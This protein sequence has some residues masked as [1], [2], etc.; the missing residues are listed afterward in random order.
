MCVVSS[1][2]MLSVAK[3]VLSVFFRSLHFITSL[4]HTHTHTPTHIIFDYYRASYT[5][6][7]LF[8]LSSTLSECLV[9]VKVSLDLFLEALSDLQKENRIRATA[10]GTEIWFHTKVGFFC[11]GWTIF[12]CLKTKF[13]NFK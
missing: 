12:T 5:V 2:M 13:Q 3:L 8:S 6:L 4:T 11:G 9:P 7:V 10:G 1:H